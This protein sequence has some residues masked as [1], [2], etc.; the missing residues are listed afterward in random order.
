MKGDGAEAAWFLRLCGLGVWL[1]AMLLSSQD[2]ELRVFIQSMGMTLR[3]GILP[4]LYFAK[5]F[6]G[7]LICQYLQAQV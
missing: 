1:R 5:K 2:G 6:K 4:A 3:A 7:G